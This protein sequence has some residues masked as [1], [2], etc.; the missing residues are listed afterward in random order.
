MTISR[1]DFLGETG[2]TL[3][4]ALAAGHARADTSGSRVRCWSWERASPGSPPPTSSRR[5]D[6]R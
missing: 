4:L 2:K 5:P 1:R 3:A 6:T